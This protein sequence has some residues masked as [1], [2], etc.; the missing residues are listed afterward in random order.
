MET[1]KK[2][3]D[4]RE[5]IKLGAGA[6]GVTA[7]ALVIGC[8]GSAGLSTST[9]TAT[10][11]GSTGG[12]GGG[13]DTNYLN[14]LLNLEYLKAQYYAIGVS[15][16]PLTGSG[17]LNSN[18]TGLPSSAV[19]FNNL[20]IRYM[21][22]SFQRDDTDHVT[23]LQSLLGSSAI[24]QPSINFN[25]FSS[26]ATTLG[27][28]SFSAFAS[29]EDFILGAFYFEDAIVT[30]Q[31][32]VLASLTSAKNVTSV[33]GLMAADCYHAGAVRDTVFN[34]GSDAFSK[35]NSLSGLR[36]SL[37]GNNDSPPVPNPVLPS[38][39]AVS[40]T[41]LIYARVPT[42]VQNIMVLSSTA[43]KGGFYPS[44]LSGIGTITGALRRPP[45]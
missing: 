19:S 9:G 16:T 28:S 25:A 12:T 24:T 1:E 11:T 27:L 7:G 33:T 21:F 42:E 20:N 44:G 29:E 26:F 18:I 3:L 38:I 30:A 6:L 35:A 4:R 13:S 34:Y 17:F 39:A 10:A 15:G 8:G 2:Q 40:Q 23:A 5:L 45:R 43:S 41:G 32:G 31:Y 36:G 14:F 37:G 22:S